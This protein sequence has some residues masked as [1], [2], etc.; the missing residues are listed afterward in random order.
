MLP[1]VA[2][3][4]KGTKLDFLPKEINYIG[5]LQVL[6]HTLRNPSGSTGSENDLVEE[7]LVALLVLWQDGKWVKLD[8][9]CSGDSFEICS[10][11]SRTDLRRKEERFR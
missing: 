7:S 8:R 2:T 1:G 9:T 5:D 10:T 4:K 3:R 6:I 11:G